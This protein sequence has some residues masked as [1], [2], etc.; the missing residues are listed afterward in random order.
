MTVVF[1]E[2][3]NRLDTDDVAGS[4]KTI[5][6]YIRYMQER[7][8]FSNRNVTRGVSEAGVSSAELYLTVGELGNQLSTLQSTVNLLAGTVN[9]VSGRV[10]TLQSQVAALSGNVSGL[11]ETVGDLGERVTALEEQNGEEPNNGG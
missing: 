2:N 7:I 4:L 3:M 5:E 10:V 6:N 8:E 9:S 11:A 1:T